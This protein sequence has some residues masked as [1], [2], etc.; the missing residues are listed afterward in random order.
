MN[1]NKHQ[2]IKFRISV[3]AQANASKNEIV[4]YLGKE[5]KIRVKAVPENGKANKAIT[6]LLA[7]S[8]GLHKSGIQ[9]LYGQNR[10][11]K[12]FEITGLNEHEI[13]QKLEL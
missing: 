6:A 2:S 10:T 13:L 7:K 4:G 3:K 12:I 9:L 1:T 11:H 8:L 5:L